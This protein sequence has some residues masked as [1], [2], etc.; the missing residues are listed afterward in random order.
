[1]IQKI[2]RFIRWHLLN[3]DYQIDSRLNEIHRYYGN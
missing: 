3:R 2:I 1:M